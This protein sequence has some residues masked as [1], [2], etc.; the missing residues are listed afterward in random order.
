M[1]LTRPTFDVDN[2][3]GLANYT[4]NQALAVKALFDKTGADAKDYLISLLDEIEIDFATKVE[5]A[6]IILGQITDGSLTDVKLS[7]VAGQIKERVATFIA[8]K[9][10][11][12]GLA[13]LGSDSKI[14]TSQLPLLSA[15]GSFLDTTT[16]VGVGATY[17]K[18]K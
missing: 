8:S 4:E 15:T 13:S 9:G 14:T 3:Q 18:T 16:V 5:V 2:I 10:Q 6:G 12:S 1:A 17:T 7:D 11:A